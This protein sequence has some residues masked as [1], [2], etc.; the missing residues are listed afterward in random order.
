MNRGL[1]FCLDIFDFEA[2]SESVVRNEYMFEPKLEVTYSN[3]AHRYH[4]LGAET[5]PCFRVKKSVIKGRV[6]REENTFYTGVVTSG[7]CVLK[8]D[9]A[10]VELDT[11]DKFFCPSGL[12]SYTIEADEDVH[13]LECFPPAW[14]Q[15]S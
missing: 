7:S 15:E 6:E 10:V 11:F 14:I 2:K 1:D 5:T 12:G 3:T 9:A 13:I 8:T 4:L